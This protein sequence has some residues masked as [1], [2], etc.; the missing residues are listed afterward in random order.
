MCHRAVGSRGAYT[1]KPDEHSHTHV[2]RFFGKASAYHKLVLRT[3]C[4][5][6]ALSPPIHNFFPSLIGL[7]R[8]PH[9]P[10][11]PFR[12]RTNE[13]DRSRKKSDQSTQDELIKIAGNLASFERL[14]ENEAYLRLDFY[15]FIC[16]ES[17]KSDG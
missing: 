9:F 12:R 11:K 4:V 3:G 14:S 5:D 8:P 10:V 7:Y 13:Q 6:R 17:A 2:H 15:K 1:A 16:A